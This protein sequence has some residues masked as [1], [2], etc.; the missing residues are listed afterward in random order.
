MNDPKRQ[1]LED[2][3]VAAH[4]AAL[5]LLEDLHQIVEDLPAP[6][7]DEHPIDWGHVGSLNHL[8]EQLAEL[9][10]HFS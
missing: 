10:R 6:G 4:I 3:Y 1:R 7:N 9:K 5:T 8:C 2:A